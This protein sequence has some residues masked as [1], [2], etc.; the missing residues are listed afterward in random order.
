MAADRKIVLFVGSPGSG[1][2]TLL[3]ALFGKPVFDAGMSWGPCLLDQ[4]TTKL[5]KESHKGILYIDTPGW[6]DENSANE[7]TKALKENGIY[8]V[9]FVVC[10]NS[11]CRCP[12][13]TDVHNMQLMGV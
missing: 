12:R 3:N 13:L 11:G 6:N 8:H 4:V 2:S 5:Q 10:P 7:I 9:F 1:K